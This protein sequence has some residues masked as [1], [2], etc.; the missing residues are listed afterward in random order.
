VTVVLGL[1]P[2]GLLLVALAKRA[3][4]KKVVAVDR[5]P[6]RMDL[7]TAFGADEL[8]DF[9]TQDVPATVRRLTGG[10]GADLVIVG[11]PTVAAM[12]TGLDCAGPG[13]AVVFFSPAEPETKFAYE[14]NR[15]YFEEIALLPSYS[16]GPNDTRAALDLLAAGAIDVER[17]ITHR[18]AL[19]QV[20]EAY[21][22]AAAAGDAAK[23][24]IQVADPPLV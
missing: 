1:G 16:C 7:A 18:F 3:G 4:A 14:P 15:A 8:V 12:G 23:V 21:R 5:V 13:A 11:P 19:E 6:F 20:A 17:F 2:M 22:L 10:V 9:S 24:L